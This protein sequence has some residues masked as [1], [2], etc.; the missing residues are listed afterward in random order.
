MNPDST[1]LPDQANVVQSWFYA[2]SLHN[3]G[4][5]LDHYERWSMFALFWLCAVLFG[6][7]LYS[8][9]HGFWN[10]FVEGLNEYQD[11]V[12]SHQNLTLIL[13]A[14]AAAASSSSSLAADALKTTT[15]SS[16]EL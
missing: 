5:L 8:F 13:D 4:H 9:A 2:L 6:M 10:G 7:Q 14:A 15:T 11:I 3:G 1:C 12:N 16:L